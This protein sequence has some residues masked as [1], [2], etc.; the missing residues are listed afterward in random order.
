ME[1]SVFRFYGVDL[2]R[3]ILGVFLFIIITLI[4][5]I[6]PIILL[7]TVETPS[8]P[9]VS[10][11][12]LSGL[13]I[14]L[15]TR[16]VRNLWTVRIVDDGAQIYFGSSLKH[17]FALSEI[18]RMQIRGWKKQKAYRILRLKIKQHKINIFVDNTGGIT[19]DKQMEVFDELVQFLETYALAHN[20]QKIDLRKTSA[21][22]A[23]VNFC[24]QK[25]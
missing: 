15:Y 5:F 13:F 16:F 12:V 10:A 17:R 18:E 8:I 9:F 1:E 11:I 24:L 14:I 3:I 20:Y 23:F 7:D 4:G 25:Q 2:R 19:T 22:P 21:K 6:L